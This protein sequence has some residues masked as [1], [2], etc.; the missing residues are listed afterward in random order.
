MQS[1]A[2]SGVQ[3]FSSSTVRRFNLNVQL[4]LARFHYRFRAGLL[5][6]VCQRRSSA[7]LPL[8]YKSKAAEIEE[9]LKIISLRSDF[10]GIL[11]EHLQKIGK[12]R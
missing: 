2:S 1:A 3:Q 6:F 10:R 7:K 12:I 9:V 11:A 4:I 5:L 8:K